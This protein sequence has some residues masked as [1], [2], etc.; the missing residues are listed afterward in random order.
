MR[1]ISLSAVSIALT[2]VLLQSCMATIFST[3]KQ[4]VRV[5][6]EPP[7]AT[8]FV[9]NV[10]AVK[11]GKTPNTVRLRRN[12]STEVRV[13]LDGYKDHVEILSPAKFNAMAALSLL[14]F[15]IPYYVDIATGAAMRLNK[16]EIRPVLTRIPAKV[17]G[18]AMVTCNSLTLHIKG[19]DKIGNFKIQG[20]P[21]EILY[22]GKSFDTNAE[23][24]RDNVVSSLNEFGYTVPKSSS[25]KLFAASTG[26]KFYLNGDV[27]GVTYDVIASNK[28]EAFAKYET[29]CAID[30]T[31]KLVNRKKETIYELKSTGKSTK[32]EKGGSAAFTDAFENAIYLALNSPEL[33]AVLVGA[34]KGGAAG[35]TPV[36]VGS[37]TAVSVRAAGATTGTTVDSAVAAKKPMVEAPAAVEDKGQAIQLVRPVPTASKESDISRAAKSVVTISNDEGHGS[38][39]VVSSDGYIV[40]NYH[41]VDGADEVIVRFAN[42][43]SVGGRVVRTNEEM[44]LALV[45]VSATNLQPLRITADASAELGSDVFAIGTPADQDLGQTVTKGIVS[46]E[47]KVEGRTFIQTD[48]SINPG[49]SGGALV[50]R[51]GMLLGIVNAK[52]VGRGIEGLGFAIPVARML[53]TLKL[54]PAK[55]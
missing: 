52:V 30:V 53:E 46:G 43:D 13:K 51:T 36:A 11:R 50:D 2:S 54:T 29:V 10:E 18:S 17:N 14:P 32:F 20:E 39:V 22:F 44:D 33:N 16:K 34:G 27:S 9:N 42:G 8:V 40:T 35:G 47:R 3:P 6:S 55:P 19:G 15:F 24:L 23:E 48:V 12:K 38:G 31:W 21:K 7:G 45:R 1:K 37:A 41:V 5:I 49:N 4:T 25:G 26:A 28:Y